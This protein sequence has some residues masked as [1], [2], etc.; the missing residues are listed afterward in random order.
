[1]GVKSTAELVDSCWPEAYRI[2]FSILR[3]HADAE[4]A[5]QEACAQLHFTLPTL[6]DERAFKCWF[7][8]VVVRKAYDI[9][10]RARRRA[11][12]EPNENTQA[13]DHVDESLDLARALNRLGPNQRITI[14]LKYYYGFSDAETA[15]I[16]GTTHA[17]IRVRLFAARKSLRRLLE[18]EA[19][20]EG[21]VC[22]E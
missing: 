17:A 18:P 11:D 8:R 10:R 14:I 19:P 13:E 21:S 20:A 6:R 1:M 15:R 12:S 7:Y 16:L 4:D 3:N 22:H 2:A 9:S 5:A